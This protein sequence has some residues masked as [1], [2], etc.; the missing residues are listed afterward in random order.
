MHPPPPPP[1]P[2]LTESSARP[3]CGA[4]SDEGAVNVLRVQACHGHARLTTACMLRCMIVRFAHMRREVCPRPPTCLII[5]VHACAGPSSNS[6]WNNEEGWKH[7]IA[8]ETRQAAKSV[9]HPPSLSYG[10]QDLSRELRCDRA[11]PRRSDVPI[12]TT[13]AFTRAHSGSSKSWM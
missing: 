10:K 11:H 3:C 5:A 13:H 1:A 6:A 9:P 8:R 12:R 7:A 4:G 2:Q